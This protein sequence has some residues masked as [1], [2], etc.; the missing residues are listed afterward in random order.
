VVAVDSGAKLET[1]RKLGVDQVVDYT[2]G[3]YAE[4]VG[5]FDVVF[6]V[7]GRAPLHSISRLLR[8]RGRYVVANPRTAHMIR[9]LRAA[10]T[11]GRKIVISSGGPT[12][13]HLREVTELVEAGELRP[14]V[15]RCY[16]LEEAADA[17]RYADSEQKLGNIV[18]V[19][20]PSSSPCP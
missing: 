10:L 17:H 13:E 14:V 9:G 11:G 8:P 16:P 4:G 3:E 7:V 1:L 2:A 18:L 15:D 5:D 6:D 20:G 19:V 12:Q